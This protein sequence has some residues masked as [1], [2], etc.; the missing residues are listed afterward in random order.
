MISGSPS[1][2]ARRIFA[3]EG[4]AHPL[5][6]EGLHSLDD[7]STAIIGMGG[8]RMVRFREARRR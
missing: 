3:E 6:V 8:L 4:V 7:I 2:S 1:F 5:G